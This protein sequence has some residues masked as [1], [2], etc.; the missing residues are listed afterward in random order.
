MDLGIGSCIEMTERIVSREIRPHY[1]QLFYTDCPSLGTLM[2]GA[3][4]EDFL[5]DHLGENGTPLYE[6][7]KVYQNIHLADDRLQ[8]GW[9]YSVDKRHPVYKLRS[10]YEPI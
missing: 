9:I 1:V 8:D 6:L 2:C 5:V 3:I 10:E 7:H 4:C